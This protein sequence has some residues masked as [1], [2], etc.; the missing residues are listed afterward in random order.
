MPVPI[1]NLYKPYLTC[2]IAWVIRVVIT[3]IEIKRYIIE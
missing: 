2:F 3:I 1:D